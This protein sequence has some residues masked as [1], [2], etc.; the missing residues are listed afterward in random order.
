MSRLITLAAPIDIH[1]HFRD[2]GQTNKEDFYSGSTAALSGGITTVFDMPNNAIPIFTRK[3][4]IEKIKIAQKKAV[5]D[6]GFYFG[7]D[8][9][10]TDE[11]EKVYDL[12]I[13]LKL[14]LTQTTGKYLVEDEKL[15]ELVFQKWPKEKPIVIHL[16]ENKVDQV[17]SLCKKYNNKIHVTHVNTKILIKKI[18]EAKRN[19]KNITCDV[20]PHHLFFTKD[21]R[22]TLGNFGLVKPPLAT[23]EDV[24]Y[25]WRHIKDIDC[26]ASDHAPH[27]KE[28]KESETPAF[29][30]P[31][32]ESLLPLLLTACNQRSITIE[33]I[34]RLTNT[35]P[36][37]IFN[38]TQDNKTYTEIVMDEQWELQNENLKTKCGWSPFHGWKMKGK[39]KRVILHGEKVME[40]GKILVQPGFGKLVTNN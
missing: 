10:N 15:L 1:V 5:C 20:T 14:Y 34:V 33:D 13:G 40:D 19:G 35:N 39:V 25:L 27:T 4:L 37:K 17:I 36:L 18:I 30:I 6:Y 3:T 29:G 26:V 38:I 22:T 16:D 9:K 24:D 31:G 7:T 28:E 21:N 8:G 12:V 23:K 11:F 32:V 2:P